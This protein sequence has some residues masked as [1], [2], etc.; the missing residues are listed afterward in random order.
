MAAAVKKVGG[1]ICKYRVLYCVINYVSY[2]PVSHLTFDCTISKFSSDSLSN[3]TQQSFL[4]P[5]S[6][7]NT[8][9]SST[10]STRRR[11][12]TETQ[13]TLS[14]SKV[15]TRSPSVSAKKDS[16][17]PTRKRKIIADGEQDIDPWLETSDW[18]RLFNPITMLAIKSSKTREEWEI[19]VVVAISELFLH[20]RHV[21]GH[22]IP[23]VLGLLQPTTPG[24]VHAASERPFFERKMKELQTELS[25]IY[26]TVC[27][28]ILKTAVGQEFLEAFKKSKYVIP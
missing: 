16:T 17:T 14:G 11:S 13:K 7:Y 18:S 26:E 10:R 19:K 4:A 21:P 1:C 23:E 12:E 8:H 27:K 9:M 6:S 24:V 3:P 20:C 28:M 25:F 15:T 22:R 2:H 5:A